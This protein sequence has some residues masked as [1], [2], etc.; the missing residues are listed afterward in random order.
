MSHV[1]IIAEA[2]VNHNG[3][4][5]QALQMVDIAAESGADAIKFQT[6]KTEN[7]VTKNAPKAQ[8]Q[9]ERTNDTESQ[10]EMLKRLELTSNDHTMLINYCKGRKIDFI[11]TPFDMESIDLLKCLGLSIFKIP[12]GEITNLPYLQKI[13]SLNKKVI[14]STGMATMAEIGEALK[15]LQMSGTDIE[16]VT[17]LH[18]NTQYPTPYEDVN[19]FAMQSIA[20]E[21]NV[22]VGYSDH[23]L[24]IEIPIA[25]VA[26]GATVIEKHFTLDRNLDGPDHSASLI[27]G[28][29]RLMVQSIRNVEKGLGTGVKQPTVSEINNISVVRKSIVAKKDICKGEIF[30][31]DNIT[32][33]RPGTGLSPM[34]W[35][36]IL[37]QV[38][39]RNFNED[40]LINL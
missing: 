34:K 25:A 22:K 24:G 33:K 40:E 3:N 7:I 37:G 1:Y 13:G 39:S 36:E 15:I 29:L 20:R 31:E 4:I 38:A 21:F 6:F 19:L 8:Y 9:K 28:E 26:L 27:P 23:S 12:S 17:V 16:K 2:G 10:F 32:V 11:S 18:A 35:N 30:T 14:L 5:E